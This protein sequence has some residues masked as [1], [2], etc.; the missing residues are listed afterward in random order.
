MFV[1]YCVKFLSNGKPLEK[2]IKAMLP[3][4]KGILVN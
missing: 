2:D 1:L 4:R 3:A